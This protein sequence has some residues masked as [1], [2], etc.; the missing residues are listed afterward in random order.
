MCE[1]TKK[2]FLYSCAFKKGAR[3]T[4]KS[5]VISSSRQC[6][7]IFYEFG[8]STVKVMWDDKNDSMVN[9]DIMYQ[10]SFQKVIATNSQKHKP[11]PSHA[12]LTAV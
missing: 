5:V 10:K 4:K 12:L 7:T 11:T 9:E 6:K 8:K 2:T 1:I 3:T